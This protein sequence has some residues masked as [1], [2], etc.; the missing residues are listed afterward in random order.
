MKEI[1]LYY[2]LG[3]TSKKYSEERAGNS[4]AD[5]VEIKEKKT[6]SKF[7]AVIPGIFQAFGQKSS[8][9]LS[10]DKN[11]T[12]YDKIVLV[13]PIWA[14]RQAP[15]MN[16]VA[17]LIPAGKKVE[18]VAVSNQGKGYGDTLADKVKSAGG[19]VSE[20]INIKSGSL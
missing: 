16:S 20:I 10:I 3:G 11:L 15:A 1:I 7:G 8:E 19:E 5:I 6:R 9:I 12:D 2:T 13:T 14:G 18:V 4:G 17:T